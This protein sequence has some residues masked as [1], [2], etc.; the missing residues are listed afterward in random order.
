MV[1]LFHVDLGFR[2]VLVT[3]R[4]IRLGDPLL[5]HLP[6]CELD[7]DSRLP[8]PLVGRYPLPHDRCPLHLHA[9]GRSHVCDQLT[10]ATPSLGDR[11]IA[12]LDILDS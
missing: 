9:Q 11:Q 4:T 5:L 6:D 3:C 10:A 12:D 1:V 2:E 7:D 8:V